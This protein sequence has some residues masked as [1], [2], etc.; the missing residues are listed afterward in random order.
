MTSTQYDKVRIW[1]TIERPVKNDWF[2]T[3]IR[4]IHCFLEMMLDFSKLYLISGW[5]CMITLHPK[6][7][8]LFCSRTYSWILPWGNLDEW[9]IIS[10]CSP[11]TF[12]YAVKACLFHLVSRWFA[13]YYLCGCLG[14]HRSLEGPGTAF[15]RPASWHSPCLQ[16]AWGQSSLRPSPGSKSR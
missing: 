7:W 16:T 5:N 15:S 8:T 4:D 2:G 6:K 10:K 9:S 1:C 14:Y 11:T 12:S 13:V 3:L